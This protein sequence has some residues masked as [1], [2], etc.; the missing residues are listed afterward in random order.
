MES[1][2][3]RDA[4]G[5]RIDYKMFGRC[6]FLQRFCQHVNFQ[7][8]FQI[9]PFLRVKETVKVVPFNDVKINQSNS[10]NA[11]PG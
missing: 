7:S 3:F 6:A 4:V 10:L 8:P 2:F 5:N 9:I 11:E 1:L